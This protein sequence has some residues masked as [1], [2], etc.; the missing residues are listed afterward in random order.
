MIEKEIRR[1]DNTIQRAEGES[2]MVEGYAVVFDSPSE[3]IG[4]IEYIHKGAITEDT[5]KRSDVFCKFNHND[6][7][8]LAR[9]KHGNGSLRLEVD[10]HGLKYAFEAPDT[11]LGNELLSYLKRGDVSSS[12][13]AFTIAQETGSEK[14]SKEGDR[15]RRDIYHIDKLF[16]VSPVFSPAYEETSCAARAKE[17]QKTSEELDAK[18]DLMLEEVEKL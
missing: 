14:W 18:L 1:V 2:R 5:I 11:A 16:D 8:V 7:K 10:E 6:E 9:C 13:F 12:S 17:I 3:D 15:L 4:W